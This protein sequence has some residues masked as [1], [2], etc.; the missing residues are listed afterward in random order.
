MDFYEELGADLRSGIEG[1]IA[2]RR[3]RRR[4]LVAVSTVASAALVA[5]GV[6]VGASQ[7]FGWPAPGNVRNDIAGVDRGLPEDMRLNPDVQNARAVAATDSSTLYAADLRDGGHCTEIVT[8]GARGRGAVCRTAAELSQQPVELTLPSDAGANAST[9]ITIG[10]RLNIPARRVEMTYGGFA[11]EIPLGD[12]NYFV[13]DVPAG[14]LA[15]G[16]ASALV[17]VARDDKGRVVARA[18][19]PNDWDAPAVSDERQPLFVS[20]RSSESDFTK[21]YGIEGHVGAE[22]ADHLEL[23]YDDGE[24]VQIPIDAGRSFLYTVPPSRVGAFMRP[25]LLVARNSRG[26]VVAEAR[27]A[28]VAFWR[29][30][31]R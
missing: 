1:L 27:V 15:A 31:K 3:L 28:A 12:D 2:R 10:G 8:D 16:H 18:T 20:T 25:Q 5:G 24:T 14:R 11:D 13:F 6:A 26:K 23:T 9:P 29:G 22:G 30:A 19:V 4:L 21:V 17:V 7:L